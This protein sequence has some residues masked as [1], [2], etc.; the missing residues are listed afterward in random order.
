LCSFAPFL[1][2]LASPD[3]YSFHRFFLF[4]VFFLEYTNSTIHLLYS[5][6]GGIVFEQNLQQS[7]KS[8]IIQSDF[9]RKSLFSFP[10]TMSTNAMNF[11]PAW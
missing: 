3:F 1:H 10:P 7:Q 5:S 8:V 6:S 11:G 2:H 4:I 9:T